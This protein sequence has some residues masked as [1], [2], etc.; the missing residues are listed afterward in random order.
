MCAGA[1]AALTAGQRMAAEALIKQFS[2]AEFDLRQQA[3]DKL[4]A[5]GPD[6]IPLVKKTL[7]ETAD[8]EVKLRCRMVLKALGGAEP[9]PGPA[10][11]FGY[12]ASKV[13]LELK[14]APLPQAVEALAEQSGNRPF[15]LPED[16]KG[17]T[18]TLSVKDA[19]YWETVDRMC[20]SLGLMYGPDYTRGG[21]GLR[22]MEADKRAN[23][24]GFSGPVV[25]KMDSASKLLYFR[26]PKMPGPRVY[27]QDGL[28][29]NLTC[30]WE[31]RLTPMSTEVE[32]T[33][34][35]SAK[36]EDLLP[37]DVEKRRSAG[38]G[39]M[40]GM[41]GFQYPP[42]RTATFTLP[43]PPADVR[44]LSEFAGVVRLEF[45]TGEKEI[46]IDPDIIGTAVGKE[47]K[48]DDWTITVRKAEKTKWGLMV[49]VEAKYKGEVVPMPAYWQAGSYGWYVVGNEGGKKTRGYTYGGGGYAMVWG[50]AGQGENPAQVNEPLKKGEH[51][52]TFQGNYEAGVYSMMLVLPN[53]HETKEYPFTIKEVPVP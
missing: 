53:V 43:M 14:D 22:L 50:R 40:M 52:I 32:L 4:V 13:T 41:P 33:K 10:D 19:P 31:D 3:V 49:T 5:L 2:A 15:V 7:E 16:L 12:D 35:Q 30:F 26:T 28:T 39:M 8:N 24:T 11:K 18:V 6:V 42:C 45:G 38:F 25:V 37:P 20:E 34:A 51:A 29:Y 1:E 9:T 21:G 47:M 23:L 44:L 36:G 27:Y 48:F 46:R 17:R